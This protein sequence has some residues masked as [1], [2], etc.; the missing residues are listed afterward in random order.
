MVSLKEKLSPK[1]FKKSPREREASCSM[2]S[3]LY[4]RNFHENS[5]RSE[6]MG[7]EKVVMK[8]KTYS[9]IFSN[10]SVLVSG[11]VSRPNLAGKNSTSDCI[12]YPSM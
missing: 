10:E 7:R 9:L 3:C 11:L 12:L 2:L 1:P 6:G 4:Q 8:R 5:D